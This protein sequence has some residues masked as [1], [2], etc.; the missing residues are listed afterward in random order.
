[1]TVDFDGSREDCPLLADLSE[2]HGAHGEDD[3]QPIN[4]STMGWN[5]IRWVPTKNPRVPVGNHLRGN[6]EV[7]KGVMFEPDTLKTKNTH[8]HFRRKTSSQSIET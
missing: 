8:S 7:W 2:A 4:G 5:E 3:D 1:M 6:L